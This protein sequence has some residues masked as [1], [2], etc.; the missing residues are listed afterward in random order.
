MKN[1]VSILIAS[2]LFA[3]AT[4]GGLAVLGMDMGGG[5]MEPGSGSVDCLEHCLS[6]ASSASAG[7]TSA[8][9]FVLAFAI[10]SVLIAFAWKLPSVISKTA[11]VR[12]RDD[13]GIRFRHRELAVVRIQD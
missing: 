9:D 1:A 10:V 11:D 12:W 2:V 7:I 6:V 8:A 5:H 3:F 13:F 4:I